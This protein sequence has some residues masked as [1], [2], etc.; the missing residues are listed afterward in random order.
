MLVM[1]IFACKSK[2]APVPGH[3]IQPKKFTL[4]LTDIRLA[5]ANQKIMT[6]HG[7]RESNYIDS[8][9]HLIYHLH[10]VSVKDVE[11]SYEFY[12]FHP[13]WMDKITNDVIDNLNHLD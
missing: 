1:G 7:L 10:N 13:E 6:Q 2:F 11:E 4:I 12:V 8:S 5:E 9:Y 3:L